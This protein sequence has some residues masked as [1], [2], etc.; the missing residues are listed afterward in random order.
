MKFKKITLGMGL[1]D[2]WSDAEKLEHEVQA[3][4]HSSTAH[5]NLIPPIM[6]Q[7]RALHAIIEQQQSEIELMKT[8]INKIESDLSN[9]LHVYLMKMTG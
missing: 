3:C 6:H 7:L 9:L 8:R 2:F 5:P 1:G 4:L